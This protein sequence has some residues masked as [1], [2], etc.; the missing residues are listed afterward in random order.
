MSRFLID[1]NIPPAVARFLRNKGFDVKEV[2]E[3][4]IPG[5][6]D[7]EIMHLARQE[8]RVLLTFDKHF[9]NILLYPLDSHY[10]VIRFRIHPPL[11][12]DILRILDQFLQ[13][14]DL[15]M[16]RRTLIVLERDGFRVRRIP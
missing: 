5:I 1:E 15:T 16:I 3:A 6:S 2:R 11:L 8:E 10:G 13:K 12:S 9:S 7:A 4:G 14:F